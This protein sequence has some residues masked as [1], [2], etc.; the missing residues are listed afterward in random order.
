LRHDVVVVGAGLAGLT[1]AI[2]LAQEGLD[3]AVV[4]TGQGSLP[5]SPAV[6]DILGYAPHLVTSPGQELPAYVAEHP[7]HPYARASLDTL[8][9]S[10]SWFLELTASLGYRGTL[11]HNVLLPTAVGGIRPTGL[12][13]ETMAAGDLGEGGEVLIVGIRNYR[14]FHARLVADNLNRSSRSVRARAVEIGLSGDARSLRPQL[15]ARRLELPPVRSELARAVRSELAGEQA[16][17]LPAVLGLSRAHEVWSE[18]TSLIGRPIFEIPTLP[19][20][21]SG[22]RLQTVLGRALRR[23]GGRILIG[24]T[25]T[26]GSG[27]SGRLQSV[28]VA[29]SSRSV[30]FE[31]DHFVL[32]TG[33]IATGGI[34]SEWAEPPREVVL[35]LPV[36]GSGDH[37]ATYFQEHERDRLGLAVDH[38]LRPLNSSGEPVYANV[39]AV[40]AILSGA[41]PWREMSG[42]GISLATGYAAA[43]A[44]LGGPL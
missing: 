8:T 35:G 22:L 28:T 40:G 39:H 19:P 32:A 10:L 21:V 43:R 17:G 33:G 25:A 1:A 18:L 36:V 7:D 14:D 34:V 12:V 29:E 13:P 9:A 16:V 37:G 42:N 44:I 20:S 6:V 30:E 31:A 38:R 2:R 3:V 27:G 11:D 4:A 23:H 24:S 15:L 5:L 26:A 41:A